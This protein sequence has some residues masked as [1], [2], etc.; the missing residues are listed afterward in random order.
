[1]ITII[2][3]DLPEKSGG[4]REGTP[5]VRPGTETKFL[6]IIGTNVLR[7]FRLAIHMQSSL[8]TDFTPPRP[9]P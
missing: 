5:L 8:L 7:V 2:N 1:M 9:L 4:G 3:I 6:D